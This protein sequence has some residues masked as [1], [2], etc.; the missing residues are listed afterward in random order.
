MTPCVGRIG[1]YVLY[2][3][4]AAGGVATVYLAKQEGASGFARV[5]AVKRMHGHLARH[6]DAMPMMRD[7]AWLSTRIRHPKVV[8]VLD[9]VEEDGELVLVMEY[10]EGASLAELFRTVSARGGKLSPRVVGALVVD[11]LEGL[12]AAHRACAE[13]G[14]PLDL[15]HRDVSPSNVL[16]GTDGVARLADFGVAKAAGRMQS[17]QQGELKGKFAYMAPE[18]ARGET[19]SSQTDIYAAGVVLWEC[20]AGRRLHYADEVAATVANILYGEIPRVDEVNSELTPEVDAVARRALASDP[21]ARYPTAAAMATA[22]EQVLGRASPSDVAAVL[23]TELGECIAR[24]KA[25]RAAVE[26]AS[27]SHASRLGRS[28]A[29]PHSREPRA[30]EPEPTRPAPPS[31]GDPHVSS[32]EGGVARPAAASSRARG[33][34]RR[35]LWGASVALALAATVF[36]SGRRDP[37]SPSPSPSPSPLQ[38]V[39]ADPP[40]RLPLPTVDPPVA[41]ASEAPKPEVVPPLGTRGQAVAPARRRSKEV[42]SHVSPAATTPSPQRTSPSQLPS[43]LVGIPTDRE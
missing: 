35:T 17:T 37:S 42:P 38:R 20:L 24:R 13:D 5:V 6:S 26:L 28:L 1:R 40:S 32:F 23:C 34:R 41:P 2:D 3:E 25:C 8:S 16:V 7:E 21:A 31:T 15:I 11:M 29:P 22:V 43:A 12:D 30:L 27:T 4:I 19:L 10:V 33:H 9:V 39:A 36:V 14:T 18:Q